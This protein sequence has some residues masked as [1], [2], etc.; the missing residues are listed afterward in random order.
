MFKE[1]VNNH[2]SRDRDWLDMNK[3]Y[4]NT[5]NYRGFPRLGFVD[6]SGVD[7]KELKA[8]LL[9]KCARL[10]NHQNASSAYNSNGRNE[11]MNQQEDG[12]SDMDIE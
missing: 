8:K 9:S 12:D 6:R 5:F 3:Y 4:E 1:Y 10:R 11:F 2:L 7:L